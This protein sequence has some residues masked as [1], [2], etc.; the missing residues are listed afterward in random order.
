MKE[1]VIRNPIREDGE[2][3]GELDFV[4]KLLYLYHG[5]LDLKNMFC[6]VNPQGELLA[7]AHLMEH[8]TFHAVGHDD[9]PDFIRYL[10]FEMAFA[11]G[12]EDA[13]VKDAL[14]EALIGRAKEI[15]IQ[16]PEKRI[17]MAQ[18]MD[19]DGH[20]ELGYWLANGF[21]VYDTIVV[22]KFD[23]SRDIP[24]YPLPDG[25]EVLPYALNSTEAREKYHQ[26]ELAAF[27]GVAWSIPHLK[28]M[29][30]SQEMTNFC[31]FSN[32]GVFL[33]N[34]STWRIT[35]ERSATE[36]VFVIPEWRSK[37]IARSI[38]STALRHLK[39][40]GKTM[41]TLGTHGNNKK[42]IRLYTQMGYE[43]YG[44]RLTVGYEIA[45]Y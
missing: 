32:D 36:N 26:A 21:T 10:T 5:G 11:G 1:F 37:G 24:D 39:E 28:W 29:Q 4:L 23:L 15:K 22:F 33:G 34:T 2:Q 17:V 7:A 8:D 31:A 14:K 3:L 25:V 6:A 35:E 40:Q 12:V 18:Y 43:L 44:F 30:G 38:I 13:A 42:A 27:D 16:Y 9:E 41:A 45:D 19:T 20:K